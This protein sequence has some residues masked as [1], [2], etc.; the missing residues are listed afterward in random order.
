MENFYACIMAGGSGE[1]FWPLSRKTTPKHLL[2]LFSERTLLEQ[3]VDR[4]GGLIPKEKILI[5][6]NTVQ[7]EKTRELLKDFPQENIFAEPEK[8]DTAPA[9]ALAAGWI[10]RRSVDAEMALLPADALIK[11]I[12]TFQKQLADASSLAREQEALVTFS[13]RPTYPATGF[14]YLELGEV[15]GKGKHG[16]KRF[17]V[18]QFFEKP[19]EETAR[20]YLESGNYGWNA[21]MFVWTVKD[22]LREAERAE[23][24]LANFARN[25]ASAKDMDSYVKENFSAMPKISID[26]ALME[27]ARKVEAIQAEF[28]WDDV[29]SWTALPAHLGKDAHGNTLKGSTVLQNAQ[30]NIVLSEGRLVALCGVSD[31]IVVET[32]DAVLVCRKDAA[33]KVKTLQEL[34]PPEVV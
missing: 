14:G 10:L 28:D 34:L 31:L 8:R 4:V 17:K 6:T 16:S 19:S 32:K 3:A 5:L 12:Q 22:F 30:D 1:R 7:L 25:L 18:K 33:Q 20:R 24:S 23:P 9:A 15:I 27:K 11:D 26:Y 29:G 13:I 2:R 21:G